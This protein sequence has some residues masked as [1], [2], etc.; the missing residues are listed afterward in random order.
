MSVLSHNRL[1][2]FH[3][4][5]TVKRFLRKRR[6]WHTS[7]GGATGPPMTELIGS[8]SRC[9][10]WLCILMRDMMLLMPLLQLS[11]LDW[12]SSDSFLTRFSGCLLCSGYFFLV[13]CFKLFCFAFLAILSIF[14]QKGGVLLLHYLYAYVLI[15]NFIDKYI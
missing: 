5:L 12:N 7:S 14:E 10:A 9:R 1:L 2:M 4:L 11:W 13:I 8:Q 15:F 3:L 6:H